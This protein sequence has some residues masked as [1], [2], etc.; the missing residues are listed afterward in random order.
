MALG[1]A[2]LML[3]TMLARWSRGDWRTRLIAAGGV[4]AGALVAALLLEGPIVRAIVRAAAARRGAEVQVE[5]VRMGLGRVWLEGVDVRIVGMPALQTRL[6]TV[7]ADLGLTFRVRG[8]AVHGGTIA[9]LGEPDEIARQFDEWRHRH[10]STAQPASGERARIAADG[11]SLVWRRS[12][13]STDSAYAW[14]VDGERNESGAA[15]LSVG[16]VRVQLPW[17][18]AEARGLRAEM[19]RFGASPSLDDFSADSTIA[20][21]LLDG[22]PR[23]SV[24]APPAHLPQP[25]RSAKA[26]DAEASAFA[27]GFAALREGQ[28]G[29]KLRAELGQVARWANEFMRPGARLVLDGL[30]LR[31][32]RGADKLNVG[33]S[34]VVVARDAGG[35]SLELLPGQSD[36][37]HTALGHP[38]LAF[39]VHIPFDSG[40]VVAHVDGGPVSLGSIGVEERDFGLVDVGHSTFAAETDLTLADGGMRLAFAGKGALEGVSI[41]HPALSASTVHDLS[42]GWR[43]RGELMLDGSRLSLD[44]GEVSVGAVRFAGK[45]LIE[46]GS[47][48]AHVKLGGGVPL[49]S[50]QALVDSLPDGLVPLLAGVRMAG[51]FALDGSIELDTRHIADLRVTFDLKKDCRFSQVPEDLSPHRFMR[52]WTR[53]VLG[54]DGL[55][56]TIESGPGSETWVSYDEISPY[57][58]T[59]VLVCEDGR[60]LVHDGFDREAIK[61]SLRDNILAGR[62][63]RGASTLT[64]QLAK[65]IYLYRD[66]TLS[67]KLQEA[68]ATML[69]EQEL[70]KKELLEL[71]LNVVEFGPGI[72]GIGPAAQHYFASVP[73]RLSLGQALYLASILPNPRH[74]YFDKE[75]ALDERRLAYLRRLMEIAH[76]RRRITDAELEEGLKEQIA[77][78]VPSTT[79]PPVG[80]L[81][82]THGETSA[83]PEP[84]DPPEEPSP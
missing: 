67:R 48:Y 26:T 20:R 49:A 21:V 74:A 5:T 84:V 24:P 36:A 51:T 58:E 65:N 77:L 32:E 78:G 57:M 10:A 70:S 28:R 15:R 18:A 29:P 2:S 79:L 42:L 27:R 4:T 9:L 44:D 43:A 35:V 41:D 16:Q 59:A 75:G 55:P 40:S 45:G 23:K 34:R 82:E 37:A 14:S 33:P 12:A 17:L 81:S 8:I 61:N 68:F 46:S 7:E 63:V 83:P 64:M 19:N 25:S 50:C 3:R 62:F 56:T 30:R 11:L 13:A 76:K 6:S 71:Y 39:G 73:A 66:K 52:A 54:A 69:L 53:E 72:Y 80:E 38:P 31:I 60:F 47:G 1:L 22:T